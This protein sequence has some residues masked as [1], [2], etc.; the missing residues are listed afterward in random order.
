MV[1]KKINCI[2]QKTK[3]IT[4]FKVFEI[5]SP[6][7]YIKSRTIGEQTIAGIKKNIKTHPS[8]NKTTPL[9]IA[10]TI[11]TIHSTIKTPFHKLQNLKIYIS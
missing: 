4:H 8:K 11:E 10:S 7:E 9:V 2:I 1:M 5:R 3:I 6:F